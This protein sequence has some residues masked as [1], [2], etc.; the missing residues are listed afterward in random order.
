MLSCR[1][2]FFK[3]NIFLIAVKGLGILITVSLFYASYQTSNQNH[4]HLHLKD[5]FHIFVCINKLYINQAV[6]KY[7]VFSVIRN[8][9]CFRTEKLV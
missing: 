5:E 4:T 8:R 3:L 2:I 1:L 7:L 9:A 6:S